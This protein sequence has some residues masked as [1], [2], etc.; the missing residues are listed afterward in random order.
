MLLRIL[1]HWRFHWFLRNN[2]EHMFTYLSTMEL[3]WW[4]DAQNLMDWLPSQVYFNTDAS[5]ELGG[6]CLKY[7]TTCSKSCHLSTFVSFLACFPCPK[8]SAFTSTEGSSFF[9]VNALR[10]VETT[11]TISWKEK[12]KEKLTNVY[13]VMSSA[14]YY[15]KIC[16]FTTNA[17]MTLN[18]NGI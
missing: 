12:A 16:F 6:C 8:Q 11:T 2:G 9:L 10:D 13:I 7:S 3:Q 14:V 15:D 18:C 1:Y 17:Y 4:N 5:L